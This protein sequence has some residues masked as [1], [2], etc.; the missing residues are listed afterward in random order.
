[1]L[2]RFDYGDPVRVIRPIRNDGTFP[3]ACRGALLVRSGSLGHVRQIGVFL[4]EQI[5]YGVHFLGADNRLVG[6]RESE[7]IAA[8]APWIPSRFD[9]R[10][11]VIARQSLALQ[12]TL[13]V[14]AGAAG[15]VVSVSRDSPDSVRY[16]VRFGELTLAVPESALSPC[17]LPPAPRSESA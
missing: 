2:P 5:I 4:Q 8:T 9:H 14:T 17:L 12:G 16:H 15:E 3:G 10:D 11:R 13:V 7:L 6:C 1:M